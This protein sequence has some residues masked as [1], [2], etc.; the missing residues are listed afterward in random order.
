LSR[1]TNYFKKFSQYTQLR[2]VASI[3]YAD[4]FL[5]NSSCIVSA[6]EF[7]KNDDFFASAGV[8]KKIRIYDFNNVIYNYR[9]L[10][11]NEKN[12]FESIIYQQDEHRQREGKS[13]IELDASNSFYFP[14]SSSPSNNNKNNQDINKQ[15]NDVS[16]SSLLPYMSSLPNKIPLTSILLNPEI[17]LVTD[18]SSYN[19]NHSY[20]SHDTS[21]ESAD[22]S[23]MSSSNLDYIT[24]YP[25]QEMACNSKIR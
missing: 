20:S 10:Y 3:N 22:N 13:R 17:E 24:R 21:S 23:Y 14:S 1:F 19:S 4:N 18:D 16:S 8:L 15:N 2:T 9:E 5:N 25:I 12:E 6:V 7:D 11:K